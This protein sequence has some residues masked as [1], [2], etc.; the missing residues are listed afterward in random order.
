MEGE[1]GVS[2]REVSPSDVWRNSRRRFNPQCELIGKTVIDV[3][4]MISSS[5]T[6]GSLAQLRFL[7]GFQYAMAIGGA[8][9]FASLPESIDSRYFV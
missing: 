4:M 8:G 9:I 5:R 3:A 2:R 6:P 7:G 1:N